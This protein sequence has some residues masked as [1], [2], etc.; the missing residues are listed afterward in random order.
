MY[1][2]HSQKEKHRRQNVLNLGEDI[3]QLVG[4]VKAF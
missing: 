1:E 3:F 4:R 2:T